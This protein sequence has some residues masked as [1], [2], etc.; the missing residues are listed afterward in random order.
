MSLR[1][2]SRRL[3]T[4]LT[5]LALRSKLRDAPLLQ[6]LAGR[7]PVDPSEASPEARDRSRE[8]WRR[9]RP[10]ADLT[11]GEQLS[12]EPFMRKVA[13]HAALHEQTRLLEIGPGYGRLLSAC[14]NLGLPF[15][16][17]TGLDL[18]DSNLAQL[19]QR[20]TD[21]RITFT[22]GDV[23][24][25][26]LESF[27]VCYS[28]LTFKHIYPTFEPALVN[29]ARSMSDEGRV[30]FDLLEG[31]QSYFEDDDVTFVHCYER[32]EVEQIA[33]RAGLRVLAFDEVEHS[34]HRKRLLVVAGR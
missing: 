20:F 7:R 33:Q 6:R 27:D 32:P 17:Y 19:R 12:G 16:S 14:L 25:T 22:Q 30:V 15:G 13:E 10:E 34:P 21:P 9:A 31:T 4:G 18:S 3:V 8:R 29:L 23:T 28:S 1:T 5:P 26:P 24:A 2:I 11:W